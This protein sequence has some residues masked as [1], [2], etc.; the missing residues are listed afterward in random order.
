[1]IYGGMAF[2]FVEILSLANSKCID[3]LRPKSAEI[4]CSTAQ[5]S[6]ENRAIA[7]AQFSNLPRP[8]KYL[9]LSSL[10]AIASG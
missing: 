9:Y 7:P 4:L 1:M 5:A 3:T 10:T 2:D 8:S 6:G